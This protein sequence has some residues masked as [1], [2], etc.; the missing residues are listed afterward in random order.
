MS[1]NRREFLKI[2]GLSSIVGLGGVST[3]IGLRKNVEASQIMLG[4]EALTAKRWAMVVNLS[5]FKEKETIKKLAQIASPQA[6]WYESEPEG[7]QRA[8]KLW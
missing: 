8:V 2:A 5:K 1:I 3:A 6:T 4:P 7:Q